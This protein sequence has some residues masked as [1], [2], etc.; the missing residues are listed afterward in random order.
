MG[1]SL[2]PHQGR[3]GDGNGP[4]GPCGEGLPSLPRP[5]QGLPPP[6]TTPA[7]KL[8]RHSPAL[9]QLPSAPSLADNACANRLPACPPPQGLLGFVVLGRYRALA[10]ST[11]G[12]SISRGPADG[13]CAIRAAG[14]GGGG[15]G[16]DAGQ[17]R[18]LSAL[19]AAWH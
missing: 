2:T 16:G 11:A 9:L 19:A 1:A 10:G 8:H 18:F 5:E 4:H 6:A 13:A 7:L 12:D 3:S 17:R 15:G 14:R